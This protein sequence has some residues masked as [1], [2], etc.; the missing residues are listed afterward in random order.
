MAKCNCE[1]G[2]ELHLWSQDFCMR[3]IPTTTIRGLVY[4]AAYNANVANR[5]DTACKLV[6]DDG[7]CTCGAC[8]FIVAGFADVLRDWL[9]YVWGESAKMKVMILVDA[10]I[11]GENK[12]VPA[13]RATNKR[14]FVSIDAMMASID[15]GEAGEWLDIGVK[16]L[17]G[18]G[19]DAEKEFE[20]VYI[21]AAESGEV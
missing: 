14:R 11:D 5:N 15:K 2:H 16:H 13:Y 3:C 7:K 1:H 20:R 12:R 21:C 4:E 6:T 8:A 10:V 17:W 9:W 19:A 18:F